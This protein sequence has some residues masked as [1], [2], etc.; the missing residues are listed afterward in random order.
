MDNGN[1][2]TLPDLHRHRNSRASQL[3]CNF[4]HSDQHSKD[5][6]RA[7]LLGIGRKTFWRQ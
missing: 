3:A 7:C 4:W 1:C 2:G 5:Q 6:E